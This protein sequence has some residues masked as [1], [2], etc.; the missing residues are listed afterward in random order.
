MRCRLY[1]LLPDV[2][3]AR[4]TVDDLLLS[5]IEERHIHVLAKDGV[6]LEGL[7]EASVLQKSDI[8]HG[9]EIGLAV[10]GAAGIVAGLLVVYF[11][12]TGVSLQLVTVLITA[13]FGAL[14][15]A[16]VSSMAARDQIPY[17]TS[18]SAR[19][20]HHHQYAPFGDCCF[21]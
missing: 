11:P 6:A 13:V 7:H 10:G 20:V 19:H 15:G 14:F 12:P 17:R 16:W 9:A 18:A 21:K 1:F 5:R 2:S 3:S 8:A 4:Q